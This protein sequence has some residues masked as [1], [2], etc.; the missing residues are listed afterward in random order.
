M[1][2]CVNFKYV[3]LKWVEHT[4]GAHYFTLHITNL[5]FCDI[6]LDYLQTI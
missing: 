3:L 6:K 1:R 2:V 4:L 5:G